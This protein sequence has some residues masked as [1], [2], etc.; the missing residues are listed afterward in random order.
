M[1]AIYIFCACKRRRPNGGLSWSRDRCALVPGIAA[2]VQ[3]GIAV[4]YLAPRPRKWNLDAVVAVDLR[5]EVHD[6][7]TT[8]LRLASF[9]QPCEHAAFGIMHD[10]PLEPGIL[11]IEFVQSRYRPVKTIEIADQ[12]LHACMA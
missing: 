12:S 9:S 6:H 11:T 7:Q 1:T 4:E 3:R 10:Q 8:L 5:G 2:A